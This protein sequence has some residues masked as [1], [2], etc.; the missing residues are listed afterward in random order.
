MLNLSTFVIK[1]VKQMVDAENLKGQN[2]HSTEHYFT[3]TNKKRTVFPDGPKT[4]HRVYMYICVCKLP[5]I[6]QT[7]IN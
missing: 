5:V 4:T 2:T 1:Y 3:R 7:M 6:C